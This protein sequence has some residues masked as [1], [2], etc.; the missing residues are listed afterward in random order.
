MRRMLTVL[1]F[2]LVSA[3]IARANGI[4]IPDDK[5]VPPLGMLSHQ[6]SVAIEDQV[7]VTEVEQVFRNHTKQ[8]LEATYIFPVPK[9]ASVRQF[10]TWINGKETP[11]EMLEADKARKIYTEIVSRTMDP[12]LLEYIGNN[13]LRVKLHAIPALSD[14]KIKISFTS[15]ATSD[16][17]MVEYVYPMRTDGRAVKT[18]EKFAL[19][20]QLKSQHAIQNIYSPTH[21][22]TL[23]RPNDKTAT[24]KFEKDQALLDKDFQL[25]YTSSTQDVGVTALT[26]RPDPQNPGYFMLLAAPRVELS[27]EQVI[28]RDMVFVLDTSGSMKG[29]R[30]TQARNAL[31]YCL[32]HL[33]PKDRFAL[34]DFSTT[35]RLYKQ[36]LLDATEANVAE[37]TKWVEKLQAN[38]G[39]AIDAALAKALAL[40]TK[41]ESRPFTVVFFTDGEPT[42]GET[43]PAAILKNVTQKNTASTRIFTFGV[44]GTDDVNV[45]LLDRLAE[46]TRGVSTY[47]R[48]T[49]DI[50]AKVS[51]LYS[52]ISNPVLSNLKMSVSKNFRLSEV[53]P[54]NLPDL[55]HGTQLVV[56]GRFDGEGPATIKLTGN[57][58]KEV[59]EFVYELKFPDKTGDERAFVEDLWARRKVGY[60]LDQIRI[61]GDKKEL[62]DEVILLAKRYG[63]TTPYTSYLIV[64]DKAVNQGRAGFGFGGG[65]AEAPAALAR[66][67]APEGQMKVGDFAKGVT[68]GKLAEQRRKLEDDRLGEVAGNGPKAKKGGGGGA[69]DAAAARAAKDTQEQLQNLDQARQA[70]EKKDLGAVQSGRLAVEN[71]TY[72]NA[73]RN[74]TQ[75]CQ[76]AVRKAN[77]RNCVEVGGVWVDDGYTP[78]METVTIKAMSAAY[79]RILEKQPKMREVFTLGNHVVWVTPS[80]KALVVDTTDGVATLEDAAIDRLF[81]AAKK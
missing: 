41:D 77:A 24:V 14:Q 29:K 80:G 6:V 7:A 13:L 3:G 46:E 58:G 38:G 73:L 59:K 25:Y 51:S 69:G 16:H 10:S 61:N 65:G 2:L 35:V 28:P 50:E 39:T 66:P 49:E 31:K 40:R 12:A 33:N 15:L 26:H 52:K 71:G 18:L 63:I 19:T 72:T 57:V 45:T 68:D 11:G 1:T 47:V 17:G 78:K 9:G 8:V 21:N 74:E 55:F 56:L 20:V 67:G 37:A 34:I 22:I 62:V 54:P 75:V 64:T 60:L 44:L 43:N 32:S 70:F 4:V 48:D 5:T 76:T 23:V 79:F 53:Y 42:V 30:M 36:D 81:V 27:K